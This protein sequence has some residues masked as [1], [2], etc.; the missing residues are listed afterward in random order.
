MK[1]LFLNNTFIL[2]L[3]LV[4]AVIIFL[5]GFDFGTNRNFL[6]TRLDNLITI[7]FIVELFIKLYTY[8]GNY[9]KSN[10]NIFDAILILISTPSMIAYLF[11]VDV[12]DLSFLLVFRITRVFKSF[13]FIKFLPG[14]D[15]LIVGVQRALKSSIIVLFGFTVYIFII[16]IFT[17]YLFKDYPTEYFNNPLVSLYST[18]KIFTIEGWFEIPERVTS[19]M[20]AIPAFFTYFYFIF[21]VISGG[22]FG[23]S[24]V[25][26]IFVDAMVSDNNNEL[27]KKIES[28]EAKIDSL[29]AG[30]SG[31]KT[32]SE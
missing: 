19:T 9:F 17:F 20:S 5:N 4:N 13:R 12:Q 1:K 26:S 25:N 21:I 32:N 30:A 29:I 8:R 23:L 2:L 14:I 11:S 16:G 27:E 10:W 6:L 24:L 22:I 31:Q 28:L 15:H 18:F 7:L 3:I